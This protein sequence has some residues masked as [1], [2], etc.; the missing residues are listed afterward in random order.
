MEIEDGT[1][2]LSDSKP[3]NRSLFGTIGQKWPQ[4]KGL[5]PTPL[6]NS[7]RFG[8]IGQKWPQY[9]GL[10]PTPLANGHGLLALFALTSFYLLLDYFALNSALEKWPLYIQS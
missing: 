2:A 6:A 5:S 4:Y 8:T 10:S 3:T 1:R 9:K 7:S